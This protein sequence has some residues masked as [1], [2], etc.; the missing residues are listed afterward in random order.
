[1]T[2][3]GPLSAGT[4]MQLRLL[5]TSGGDQRLWPDPVTRRNRYGAPAYPAPDE[6]WFSSS[7]ASAVTPRG[8]RAAGAALERLVTPDRETQIQLGAWFD[9]IRSRLLDLYGAPGC[10]VVLSASGTEA[11]FVALSAALALAGGPVVNIVIAPA[12]TGSGVPA[13]AAGKHFLGRSSL[14]GGVVAGERLAAWE[15]ARIAIENIEIRD[16]RGRPRDPVEVDAEAVLRVERAVADRQFPLLHVLGASKTGRS[17]V[18]RGIAR[19]IGRAH[20][21]KALVVVDACQLRCSS[22]DIRDDLAAGLAVMITGSKFAGGPAFCGA[23]LL[24]PGLVE[25]LAHGPAPAQALGDYSARFD[26]P[27]RLRG[28]L[29]RDLEHPANLGLGLR[30]TAALAEIEAF[31]AVDAR[32]RDEIVAAFDEAVMARI[33]QA[34]WLRRLDADEADASPG[35]TAIMETGGPGARAVYEALR[36]PVEGGD[37]R[38]D[39]VCH[40][41]QP[42]PVGDGHALRICASMP[43][44][45][46]VAER[47]DAG[48]SLDDAM[49]PVIAD[50]DLVFDKWRAIRERSQLSGPADAARADLDPRDWEAFRRQAHAALDGAIDR[51]EHVRDGP[52]WRRAPDAVRAGFQA[53]LPHAGRPLPEVLAEFDRAIAPYG[54]GNPHP[55]FF[56]WVHGAG[57]PVGMLAEM[58]AAGLNANCGGRDHIGPLVER[59]ITAWMAEAFGFP[60]TSS[61]VF[62]TGAS[63]AN[64]LGLLVARDAAL[65]HEVRRAGLRASGAQ[66]VAYASSEAHACVAQSLE[67]SGLGSDQLRRIGCDDSGAMRL[68]ELSEA[69]A[70]DRAAGVVPFLVVGT[71]G[72]VNFGAFDDI[73]ALADLTER[74]RLWLHVDGAFGALAA[75]SPRLRPRVRGLERAQSVAFDFHKWAHAPYDAGFLLVRDAEAHRAT[76][77]SP[78][79]YLTRAPRGLAA[80]ETWPADLG[81][82]LSRGFRAL[83]VWF[84]LQTLGAD[85]LA[86]AMEANCDAAAHLARR[87]AASRRFE[88]AAPVPLNI[89]CFSLKDDRQGSANAELVMRLQ[90][91]GRAAPSTTVIGG[92]TV[93]RAAI[94]NH[95]T[96]T[97][98]V[99]ALLAACEE[100]ARGAGG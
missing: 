14:G 93:I 58:L 47:R 73:A 36:E 91:S 64:F 21:D 27:A 23:L 26:W 10:E 25:R 71:A 20:G 34:P 37:A 18:S 33:A 46:A 12:E 5:M 32:G 41:G 78:A 19:V 9:G 24:P 57:T 98:D 84:T 79:A 48:A 99:D 85:A 80:G 81:P 40:L 11:E 83:K 28:S 22:R 30:W 66:L 86:G 3:P 95:R 54:V 63:Q 67:L 74:E 7:T 15:G 6:V 92:R 17:G 56:G 4:E 75:L 49:A 68:D 53:S 69:I 42:A 13:A 88:L 77:A 90:E 43:L 1:M 60:A 96:T 94:V 45:T 44:V 8:W 55:G 72:S 38:L 52:V 31:E 35:L 59:Q 89:V 76:F 87:I 65:G 16:P 82:D 2:D 62:V 100:F 29:G 97:A 51:L 50:L 61:G 70:G 39:R